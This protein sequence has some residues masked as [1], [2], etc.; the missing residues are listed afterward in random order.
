MGNARVATSNH[1]GGARFALCDGSM[2][3][4]N[5]NIASNPVAF[6]N[7]PGNPNIG[8]KPTGKKIRN[9]MDTEQLLGEIIEGLPDKYQP[10]SELTAVVS[11][12]QTN[13][14][15]DLTSQ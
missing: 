14:D 4:V 12:Q 11:A 10:K 3:F 1:P 7:P 2:R 8:T 15:F 9:P 5:Q 6:N 13:F